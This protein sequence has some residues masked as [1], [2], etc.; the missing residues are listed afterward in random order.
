MFEQKLLIKSTQ[1]LS[2][3]FRWYISKV[4]EKQTDNRIHWCDG[5]T[6]MRMGSSY[7]FA[8][9]MISIGCFIIKTDNQQLRNSTDKFSSC[10]CDRLIVNWFILPFEAKR[11]YNSV[12]N[13]PNNY[14]YY[15][16]WEFLARLC[17]II[18]GRLIL[19]ILMNCVNDWKSLWNRESQSMLY[20]V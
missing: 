12:T 5:Q 3:N 7:I 18:K 17:G 1:K 13:V 8:I 2:A 19:T 14:F 4:R 15:G 11:L 6:L 9:Y 10:Y 20:R 16:L